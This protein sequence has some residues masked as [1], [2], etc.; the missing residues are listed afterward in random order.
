MLRPKLFN[1]LKELAVFHFLVLYELTF[2]IVLFD[3]VYVG[4]VI[5]VNKIIA[6]EGSLYGIV[7]DNEEVEPEL[8][9]VAIAI[10]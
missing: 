8:E 10:L 7:P 4:V 3:Y 6:W 9:V 2:L 5:L 1:S